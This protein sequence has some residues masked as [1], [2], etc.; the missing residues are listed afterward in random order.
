MVSVSAGTRS[1]AATI[2]T[3][4]G[5]IEVGGLFSGS[6]DDDGSA[7]HGEGTG[8]DG[9]DGGEDGPW[10]APDETDWNGMYAGNYWGY[11]SDRAGGDMDLARQ[12]SLAKA[13]DDAPAGFNLDSPLMSQ[14]QNG[15]VY[16][17]NSGTH[18]SVNGHVSEIG[19]GGSYVDQWG[20]TRNVRAWSGDDWS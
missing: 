9:E 12:I 10:S 16:T 18:Y 3:E 1:L 5:G 6:S 13:A 2:S 17:S 4:I 8:E 14:G 20:G 7:A 15:V 19:P 11:G